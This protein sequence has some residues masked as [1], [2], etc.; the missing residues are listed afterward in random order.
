MPP[1]RWHNENINRTR[2][3]LHQIGSEQ[4]QD[5]KRKGGEISTLILLEVKFE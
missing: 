2:I 5:K 3:Q 4:R 1:H